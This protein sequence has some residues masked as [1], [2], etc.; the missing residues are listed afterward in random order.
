MLIGVGF[1]TLTRLSLLHCYE[2]NFNELII[3]IHRTTIHFVVSRIYRTPCSNKTHPRPF[4][5]SLI[6]QTLI[7]ATIDACCSIEDFHK[8]IRDRWNITA[9]RLIAKNAIW[10]EDGRLQKRL[11]IGVVSLHRR[12]YAYQFQAYNGVLMNRR[13]R[14]RT[15][16]TSPADI[17]TDATRSP[18]FY[19]CPVR[20]VN[21]CN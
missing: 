11:A 18:T 14:S 3:H 8:P 12:V 2:E 7:L 9:H 16:Q 5:F 6:C 15:D 20:L 10:L 21:P 17:R 19:R 1:N 4:T 13:T